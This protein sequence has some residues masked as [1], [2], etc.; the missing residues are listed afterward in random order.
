MFGA[1]EAAAC[2]VDQMHRSHTS[3][4][5]TKPRTLGYMDRMKRHSQ[6]D[7][8]HATVLP[9]RRNRRQAK[10]ERIARHAP[11]ENRTPRRQAT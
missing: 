10:W 4:Y 5:F 6:E 1:D 3:C 9:L 2:H 11:V 7:E 8:E